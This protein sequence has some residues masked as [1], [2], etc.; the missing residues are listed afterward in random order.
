MERARVRNA[1]QVALYLTYSPEKKIVVQLLKLFTYFIK[2]RKFCGS[3][4]NFR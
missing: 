1:I 4:R 3:T 2:A